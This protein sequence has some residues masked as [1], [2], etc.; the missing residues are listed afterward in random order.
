MTLKI[1]VSSTK[2]ITSQGKTVHV[3][4]GRLVLID[5]QW[6]DIDIKNPDGLT[7]IPGRGVIS[8]PAENGM[9]MS[10]QPIIISETEKILVEDWYIDD[11]MAIRQSVTDDK[12]YWSRRQ[13]YNKI[14]ALPQHFSE[15]QLQ[16]IVRGKYA[17]GDTVMVECSDKV[18][19][20]MP[21]NTKT[22]YIKSPLAIHKTEETWEEILQKAYVS[23]NPYHWDGLPDGFCEYMVNHYLPPT[24]K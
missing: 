19:V 1:T 10:K 4:E 6:K 8:I 18:T 2:E 13:D 14:L 17:D 5:T 11:T 16:D 3:A 21:E 20:I 22:Y 12:D 9:N 24:K 23:G 7:I 15:E